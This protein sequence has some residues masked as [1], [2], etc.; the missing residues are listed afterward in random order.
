MCVCVCVDVLVLIATGH[1]CRSPRRLYPA[2]IP[3]ARHSL[4]L[5]Y[6]F[7]DHIYHEL[8][9]LLNAETDGDSGVYLLSVPDRIFETIYDLVVRVH[10]AACMLDCLHA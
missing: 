4:S 5:S 9:G 2:L 3:T 10:P 7:G 1:C 6:V 8:I